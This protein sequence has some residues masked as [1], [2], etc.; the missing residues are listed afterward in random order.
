[1]KNSKEHGML[2]GSLKFQ[3]GLSLR[4]M[5]A[6][7]KVFIESLYRS[8]RDDLRMLDAEDDFIE[9]LITIQHHAQTLGYGDM[10]PNAM[11]FVA[12]YLRER[13]GRVVL[14]FGQN[15]IRVVDI[16][17]IPAARGKGYGNQLLQAVQLAAS[18]VMAP[19]TLSVRAD[20]MHAKQ[21]YARLGF[22]VE[23]ARMPFERMVWYPPASG[24]FG[25]IE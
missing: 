9:D 3:G 13:I 11:Y 15:E 25:S 20:H 1:V 5:N 7:D 23:E 16:A 18:K 21:L 17:L 10:F 2:S 19:V 4:P 24:N 12:E 22:V 6:S 8:T 14:D